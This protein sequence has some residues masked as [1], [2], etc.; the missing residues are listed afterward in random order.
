MYLFPN[1]ATRDKFLQDPEKYAH[2]DLVADGNSVVWQA[3]KG[4]R[5][6]GSSNHT[7]VVDGFLYKFASLQDQLE[8]R[9]NRLRYVNFAVNDSRTRERADATVTET[10]VEPFG[11]PLPPIEPPRPS[12]TPSQQIQA[13]QLSQGNTPSALQ[14]LEALRYGISPQ[15]LALNQLQANSA[16]QKR[17]RRSGNK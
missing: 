12:I 3:Q 4:R 17:H 8:F 2:V 11:P 14:T 7:E 5:V 9:R 13:M 10:E 15:L 1:K 6:A 16:Q